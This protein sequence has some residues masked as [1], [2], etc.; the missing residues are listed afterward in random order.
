[1]APN[2]KDQ[3]PILKTLYK[4]FTKDGVV[5]DSLVFR[6]HHQMSAYV[7]LIGFVFTFI[8]NYLDHKSITC[9]TAK[10]FSKYATS[11]CWIH[12]MGY[13]GRHLQ[14]T[15]TGCYVD[16]N[17]LE[18]H[19]DVFV[20][21][22]YLWLPY[23]LSFLFA[24]SKLPHSLWKR[25]FENNLI[26][27]IVGGVGS[28]ADY[29][30]T[31]NNGNGGGNANDNK[32]NQDDAGEGN[33]GNGDDNNPN[34]GNNK[35]QKG[36]QNNQKGGNQN[37]NQQGGGKGKKGQQNKNQ[38]QKNTPKNMA[39]SF[40]EFRHS[41]D[42]Y[43]RN[44]M[45]LETLNIFTLIASAL[46]THWI[47]NFKFLNY[48]PQVIDYLSS[49]GSYYSKGRRLHDPMCELFPTEVSCSINLGSPTGS[50]DSSNFLCILQNNI[51]NQ[52]YFFV[53]WIWWTVVLMLSI[54]GVIY[55]IARVTLFSFSISMVSRKYH[56]KE[57]Q[58]LGK[59]TTSDLFVLELVIQNLNHNPKT[60]RNFMVEL[61]Q[62][63]K[64]DNSK[65]LRDKRGD[66]EDGLNKTKK[67]GHLESNLMY[68]N[69]T[70]KKLLYGTEL[71]GNID[72]P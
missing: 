64:E 58:K 4:W 48:G 35:N 56:G 10:D 7:I 19:E 5:I 20:T 30:N 13:V 26:S 61:S 3:L 43:Q 47:L 41:Y 36:N 33:N 14:G 57:I 38:P 9:H 32:E 70:N 6:L 51:F 25:Q 53:L 28:E 18:G 49:Y 46:V 1:M 40:I 45:M 23:L 50:L 11:F 37:Q 54:I 17:K 69:E 67:N 66:L 29:N 12:G 71:S 44:F 21:S 62:K 60:V 24:M 39:T 55:R 22:Y 72:I 63:I 42:S 8:E 59:L 15:A 68:T 31:S 2:L 52:K 16:Q 27:S 34:D 65:K